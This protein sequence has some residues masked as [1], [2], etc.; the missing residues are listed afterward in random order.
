MPTG[1]GDEILKA[2]GEGKADEAIQKQYSIDSEQLK[3]FKSLQYGLSKKQIDSSDIKNYYP[4][5]K[6]FFTGPSA[7]VAPA[8]EKAQAVTDIERPDFT[9]PV[10]QSQPKESTAAPASLKHFQQAAESGKAGESLQQKLDKKYSESVAKINEELENS[11]DV[12]RKMIRSGRYQQAQQQGYNQFAEKPRSDMPATAM[13]ANIKNRVIPP[14]TATQDQPVTP[15]EVY[16]KRDEIFNDQQQVR[17]L[18]NQIAIHKPE[19]SKELQTAMY[20]ADAM[21]RM[22]EKPDIGI[23]VNENLHQL[24]KG[25]LKYNA[26]TGQLNEEEGFLPSI[27]TGV[28]E[29]T[30][31][32]N[33]Y[34]LFQIPDNDLMEIMEQRRKN[35]DP[36]NPVKVPKGAGEI[37]QMLGMEWSSLLQGIAINTAG[38]LAAGATGGLSRAA[39]PYLTAAFT[40][41]EYYK[42]GYATAFE[43]T[44]NEARAQDKNPEQALA[45]AKAQA[46]TEGKYDAAQGIVASIVGSRIGIKELPKYN[47]SGTF[48]NA[49]NSFLQ[50]SKHFA[51]GTTVEGL[52]GSLI[53]GY[54]QERKDIEAQEKG[55]FRNTEQDIR[56]A[57]TGMLTFSLALGAMTHFGKGIVDPDTYKKIR[58]FLGKQEKE[59]VDATIGDMVLEGQMTQEDADNIHKELEQQRAIDQKLPEDIK[60]ISRMAMEEKIRERQALEKELE[61]ADEYRHP[62]IK[63]QIKKINDDLVKHSQHKKT[64][65]ESETE[66]KTQ[67]EAEH[68]SGDEIAPETTAQSQ[69]EAGEKTVEGE[70]APVSDKNEMRYTNPAGTEYVLRGDQ[71]FHVNNK[72]EEVP[73]SEKAMQTKNTQDLIETIRKANQKST[74]NAIPVSKKIKPN[75]EFRTLDMG[76]KEGKP[77]TTEE[78]TEMKVHMLD[79]NVPMDGKDGTGETG[80][81][82]VNRVISAWDKLKTSA[83]NNAA[84]ITHSSVL[85]AIKAWENPET[86]KGI[87]K[88]SDPSKMTDDQWKAFAT[89]Y[90]KES[91]N[92]GDIETFKHADKEIHVVRHGQTED[93]AQNK[94]RS[95]NTNL[96]KKGIEQGTEVG[97]ILNDYTGGN[98]PEIVTSDLPRT[99]H[100]SN[101]I[102]EQLK[103]KEN[104]VQEQSPTGI[105]VPA[106]PGDSEALGKGNEG[107]GTINEGTA[108]PQKVS[109]EWKEKYETSPGLQP[110]DELGRVM[111]APL[112]NA[113]SSSKKKWE[114][115]K[116]LAKGLK[117]R[118]IYANAGKGAAG[119]Y[120][121]GFK[122]IKIKYN[123]D[124]DTTAHEIGHAINDHFDLYN[125]LAGDP[126]ILQELD[127]FSSHGSLPPSNHPNPRKY[128]DKEGF[129]EWMRAYIVNPDVA[130]EMA[131]KL[132]ELYKSTTSESFQKVIKQFSD[133]YRT[134]RF[135]EGRDQLLSNV[136]TEYEEN[137]GLLGKLFK[138]EET[139]SN[140]NI[141][142][143]DRLAANFINP[144][145]AF[146]KA[147]KYAKGIRGIDNVLP[148]NDP[149][150]LSRILNGIDGKYGEILKNGMIDAK[151][152]VL[153]DAN[154]KPKN[155]KWLLE[156]LDNTDQAS[157]KKDMDDAIALMLAKRT[158]ELSAR[159]RRSNQLIGVGEWGITD[160]EAAQKT[161]NEFETGDPKRLA[162]IEEAANRY[163]E[164]ANDML[165]YT[166][167]KGRMSQEQ[168]DEIK[169][170]NDEYVALHRYLQTEPDEEVVVYPRRGGKELGSKTEIT[171]KVKGSTKG[172][173]NPY[174]S[175]LDI[176]YKAIREADR[177]EVMVAFRNMLVDPR[178]SN[179]GQPKRLADVGIIGEKG[180]YEAIP[181][182]MKGKPEYWIFQKDIY[183]QLK[184][185]DLDPYRVPGF[186]RVPGQILR[187]ATVHFPTFAGRNW[188]RDLQDRMIKSTTGS[189][190]KELWGNKEDWNAIARAGG[191]N[192]GYYLKSKDHYYGLM[193][194]A[195]SNITKKKNTFVVDPDRLKSF[196][197]KYE[198]LLYKGETSN[199]VAEYRS[200]FKKAKE[201]GMDDYNAM[202]FAAFKARDLVDFA[203][204]GHYMRTIN[205][206]IPFSNAAVQGLRSGYISAKQNWRGFA[207]RMLAYSVVPGAFAWYL[208]N[209]TKE[210][211]DR[212]KELPAYQRDMFWNF[213]IAPNKWLSLPKPY[214]L[215]LPQAGMDRAFSYIFSNDKDAF[216]GYGADIRKLLLPIDEGNLTGPYQPVI[217]S[218]VNHDFFRDN[219]IIQP[220]ED[221]LD[222]SLRHTETASRLGQ[223][224]QNIS[225]WDAR[226][227]DYFIKRQFSYTGN[228][229]LKLSDMGKEDSRHEFD[230]TDTGLFKRSPAYNSRSVQEM[231]QYAKSFGLTKTPGYKAFNQ[232]VGDYFTAG[233]D[234]EKEDKGKEMY[235]FA[236]ELLSAWKAEKVSE[237]QKEKADAKKE[238]QKEARKK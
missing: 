107:E 111:P 148:A 224:L 222:L 65:N 5:L 39:A 197:H 12:I 122:G 202:I 132:T 75:E 211:Q 115:I 34:D 121:P 29:R 24:E 83:K 94:F 174:A 103:Q 2:I 173:E 227:W 236:I 3:A 143:V 66:A 169:A 162:R 163:K 56:D 41:P 228:F 155:L 60:D 76:T 13:L 71:L 59:K 85:K 152:N 90:N 93:N 50:S 64:E 208:N 31:Q 45:L 55:L 179:E 7:P 229:V 86:W 180:D 138:K 204:A 105:H 199:R 4:E 16:A 117:Q 221:V 133:D 150:I 81:Q 28:R 194:E 52:T 47:L 206:V 161:L 137:K 233:S 67:A 120:Y 213:R 91:T 42:R 23:K 11:D 74:D 125:K 158:V 230:L 62:E 78:R 175:L 123:G 154:G 126:E 97:K 198:D 84:L 89:E 8:A 145:Q 96:T 187:F 6:K 188:L 118:I 237:T 68:Q 30:K 207:G 20:A 46:E 15:E 219:T 195:M 129:A 72:G 53:A 128:I 140:F 142:W 17:N 19:K 186:L 9:K 27:V 144:L 184:A 134:W 139:D 18:V 99:I 100:T 82:F 135:S 218:M 200:A 57:V 22:K 61:T 176:L 212:Y 102:H 127:L 35:V 164:L 203:V 37:G 70:P 151:G 231:I 156:P 209:R 119:A 43:R 54:T 130:T 191:L 32:L 63:E 153:M 104:A 193:T 238:A 157:I 92:N 109:P 160:L 159:F 40:A 192:S 10:K 110:N 36:D 216:Q 220:D 147:F 232:I 58:Y 1:P 149:I 168:Y 25:N 48:K 185:F 80:K 33:D 131:P 38:T 177:N 214:E 79:G 106:S 190:I 69:P 21:Q 49:V 223:L 88:P 113:P 136:R 112:E 196:W 217:E 14:E 165:K 98:V 181:I 44:Y 26:V 215:A 95:G 87:E 73:F 171:Q 226:K 146:E 172:I 101:L 182:F 201:Q 210:D 141:N 235:D 116:D 178:Y 124:L 166:V 205:Q 114:I 167:Q 108:I 170:N 189:G 234:K 183:R 51:V 225:G 77:E